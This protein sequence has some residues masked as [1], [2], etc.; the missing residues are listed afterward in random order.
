MILIAFG[1]NK[2]SVCGEPADT[3]RAALSALPE[4]GV[5]IMRVSRFYHSP[6]WPDPTDPPYVNAVVAVE[7]ALSPDQ[8]LAVLHRVEDRFGRT[9]REPNAQRTL[10]L[11]ILDYEGRVESPPTGPVL[12]HPRMHDRPFV[13]RPLAE[14]RPGWIHPVLARPV[15]ALLQEA[16]T[17]ENRAIPLP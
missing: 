16:E 2:P 14:I 1:A 10:D 17:Q 5:R 13:L 15:E 6:A 8:L 9:R 3:L 7:T 11:D 12:P 4:F